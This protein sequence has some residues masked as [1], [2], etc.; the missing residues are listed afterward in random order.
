[1]ETLN[2]AIDNFIIEVTL[3]DPIQ[4]IINK[5][6]SGSFRD[7]D[8]KWLN[9]KLEKFTEIACETLGLK[10][11]KQPDTVNLP[12]FNDYVKQRFLYY[13]NTLLNYF[14]AF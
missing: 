4:D 12:H 14:K 8:I 13:F 5:L 2:P 10:I 7:C 9:G 1:M 6:N 11:D 3:I